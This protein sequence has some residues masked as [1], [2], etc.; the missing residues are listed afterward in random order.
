MTLP[1]STRLALRQL[2]FLGPKLIGP[3]A[4]FGV[5]IV[6]VFT[7]LG[8]ENALY[9]SATGLARA[10]AADLVVV[11]R[12]FATMAF[13][14]PWLDRSILLEAAAVPGVAA[15]APLQLATLQVVT[16]DGGMASAWV[17]GVD[18]DAPALAISGIAAAMPRLRAT[19]TAVIDSRSREG[20][21]DVV[22]T[23]AGGAPAAVVLA[24]PNRS[25]GTRVD[26]VGLFTLGPT[27][28]IDGTLVMSDFTLRR[29]FGTPAARMSL[30]LV[31]V[32]PGHA[33]PSVAGA[34]ARRLGDEAR[35]FTK[36]EFV[37]RESDYYRTNTP[38][39][40]V[41]RIG[42]VV[43]LVIGAVFVGQT[44][45]A[46][47]EA[48][49]SEYAVLKALGHADGLFRRTVAQVGLIIAG[50][51]FPPAVAAALAIYAVAGGLTGL[52]LA[53]DGRSLLTVL[54]LTLATM[55]V[56]VLATLGRLRRADPLDLFA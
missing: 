28:F 3:L 19:G 33:A 35:V 42:V 14:Q 27:F 44:L 30:G 23:L 45:A 9:A 7:Q 48:S 17:V 12:Q 32:A 51:V 5:A 16:P 25:I 39:G 24:S 26:L 2:A 13:P 15:V 52:D 49:L 29:V 22:A 56:A 34:L 54:A 10:V 11:N 47:V 40:I 50:L 18:P 8:F 43:G 37:A 46:I 41:F 6:L 31:T 20:Y 36:A 4:G 55:A 53:L 21:R 38:I 1:L